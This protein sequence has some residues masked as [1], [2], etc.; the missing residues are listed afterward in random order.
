[1]LHLGCE[2]CSYELFGRWSFEWHAAPINT[3]Q[4]AAFYHIQNKQSRSK[5]VRK[6][7]ITAIQ[8]STT[9]QLTMLRIHPL[10]TLLALSSTTTASAL[11]PPSLAIKNARI[12]DCNYTI[13]TSI[14]APG[15]TIP[16][17]NTK[18]PSN[19][20]YMS[21]LFDATVPRNGMPDALAYTDSDGDE[22]GSKC[23]VCMTVGLSS[24]SAT[25]PAPASPTKANITH[26][27][28]TFPHRLGPGLLEA[29]VSHI[30]RARDAAEE[31]F[32]TSYIY[33]PTVEDG[34]L[35]EL[36]VEIPMAS[37]PL[38]FDFGEREADEVCVET[39]FYVYNRVGVTGTVGEIARRG[40]ARVG[41]GVEWIG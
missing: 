27:T 3:I 6:K 24:S 23:T 28:Y 9:S 11:A 36:D 19:T 2:A 7:A 4:K 32:E 22:W 5:K 30:R 20:T 39:A 17:T 14:I 15:S 21:M 29:V 41:V 35:E 25:P 31:W 8:Q 33:G 26:L 10:L 16:N 18:T 34:G 12:L 40:V 37:E 1:M 38:Q 13:T